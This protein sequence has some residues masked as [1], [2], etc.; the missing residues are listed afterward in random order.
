MRVPDQSINLKFVAITAGIVIVIIYGS[1]FPFHFHRD[2]LNDPVR[3]L[4][5]TWR[6]PT[7][8]GDFLANLLLYFPFGLFFVAAPGR[9]PKSICVALATLAGSALSVSMELV[10]FY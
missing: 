4:L 10:Q 7:G 2:L 5:G 3:A 1:L 6:T 9:L 8:R